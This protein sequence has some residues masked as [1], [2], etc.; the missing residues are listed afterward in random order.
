MNPEVDIPYPPRSW[1]Q[2]NIKSLYIAGL[3]V[4]IPLW[5]LVSW[6][7]FT[8]QAQENLHIQVENDLILFADS[9]DSELEKYR[10]VPKMLIMDATLAL[11][12]S[13]GSVL[14]KR[15]IH[16]HLNHI[17]RVTA[18]DE[19]FLLDIQGNTMASTTL[20]NQTLNYDHTPFFQAAING[21]S[22]GF[23]TLGV[24]AGIRGYYFSEPIFDINT[25]D[26]IGVV[27]V[28]VNM[29]RLERGWLNKRTPMMITDE[30]GIVIASSVPSWLFT[31]RQSLSQ[32][33]KQ[34]IKNT[35]KYPSTSFPELQTQVI[36]ELGAARIVS[37]P[38]PGYQRVLEVNLPLSELGWQLYG[39][40]N[41]RNLD[42][43]IQ[44]NT[45]LSL[46]VFILIVSL[47]YVIV[48][49]RLQFQETLIRREINQARLQQ[50]KQTLELRV[51]KRTQDLQDRNDELK[52]AQTELIHA[53]KLAT[54][55]QMATSVT[56]EINQPLTAIQTSA[57]NAEQWL[58][59][60]NYQR[61]ANNISNIK[62]LA[63][64]MAAITLHL[65]TFG[66]K[67][68]N[69]TNW[70]SLDEAVNNA[71]QLVALRCKQEQ[72]VLFIN[73][74]QGVQVLADL[75]RLEQVL[76]NLLT[77]ALDAMLTSKIKQL[78]ID[79]K[80]ENHHQMPQ[81]CLQVTDTGTGI[82]PEHLQQLF[83]PFFTTKG[84]GVGLG[85]GLSISYSIIDAMGGTLS[86]DN[87]PQG[88][89]QFCLRLPCKEPD[90]GA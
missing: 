63:K 40:G 80:V 29:A 21:S 10:F 35:T 65:K 18:A 38:K 39:H 30:Y 54:L 12:A 67:T 33:D 36:K 61:V 11:A 55:G 81:I 71:V 76:I 85:L 69:S 46:L 23:F 72:I 28:K 32:V 48:Q 4:L 7:T 6:Y 51:A 90:R 8:K 75:V 42:Y 34:A 82:N 25:D 27:V 68:D 60:D 66:R 64:K 37:L 59:R 56:H 44:R 58:Q 20:D 73:C 78:H 43:I 47:A 22:G 9:L 3:L 5:L 19:V 77:N 14:Q 1:L 31:S 70:V 86:G 53:A 49:R 84:T 24:N 16:D 45:A 17:R 41:L 2:D 13:N 79:C 26:V 50:A 87:G 15:N 88:G 89:A 57:D 62:K 83:D 52:Q 74:H